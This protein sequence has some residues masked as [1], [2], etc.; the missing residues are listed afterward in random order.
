M[1]F[2][3]SF[4]NKNCNFFAFPIDFQKNSMNKSKKFLLREESFIFWSDNSY[5]PYTKLL[6]SVNPLFD[7]KIIVTGF[8]FD[9][10]YC[11]IT[12]NFLLYITIHILN[13]RKNFLLQDLFQNLG[14]KWLEQFLRVRIILIGSNFKLLYFMMLNLFSMFE[15][16]FQ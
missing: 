16:L 2:K 12:I 13:K 14:A 11:R 8:F 9:K 6:L 3:K 7:Y 10:K 5:Q 15:V 1:N 4:I